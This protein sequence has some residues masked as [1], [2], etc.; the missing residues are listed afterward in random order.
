MG[1]IRGVARPIG[2]LAKNRET[3][4]RSPCSNSCTPRSIY[5]WANSRL[6]VLSAA[7]R[8]TFA[9]SVCAGQRPG[10]RCTRATTASP[11]AASVNT[12]RDAIA[13]C[14]SRRLRSAFFRD[15]AIISSASGSNSNPE[16][17]NC[18]ASSSGFP[19]VSSKSAR[20]PSCNHRAA[21]ARPALSCEVLPVSRQPPLQPF[22]PRQQRFA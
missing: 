21:A 3:G 12:A 17:C 19:A 6:T 22:P 16:T 4:Q 14:R 8:S 1:G 15:A 10:P 13:A 5:D 20:L 11:Q 7:S 9:C 18:S 2:C